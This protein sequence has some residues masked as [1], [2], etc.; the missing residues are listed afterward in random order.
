MRH[1]PSPQDFVTSPMAFSRNVLRFLFL[2]SLLLLI[3]CSQAQYD[4]ITPLPSGSGDLDAERKDGSYYTKLNASK[5]SHLPKGKPYKVF[6]ESYTPYTSAMGFEEIGVASWYGPGFHGKLTANGEKYNQNDITAAHKLLPFNTQIRVTNLENGRSIVVRINDRGPFSGERIIDLSKGAAAQIDMLHS[7]TAKVH[8]SVM[9]QPN[10]LDSMIAGGSQGIGFPTPSTPSQTTA[11]GSAYATGALS[12]A[13]LSGLVDNP[14][15]TGGLLNNPD[16]PGGLGLAPAK[17][18]RY[19]QPVNAVSSAYGGTTSSTSSTGS[20]ATIGAYKGGTVSAPNEGFYSSDPDEFGDDPSYYASSASS[21]NSIGASYPAITPTQS[22]AQPTQQAVSPSATSVIVPTQATAV[23]TPSPYPA[24]TYTPSNSHTNNLSSA[25]YPTAQRA[26]GTG[27]GINPYGG[28]SVQT[29]TPQRAYAPDAFQSAYGSGTT[30]Y[31]VSPSASV[32]APQAYI[33]AHNAPTKNQRSIQNIPQNLSIDGDYYLQVALFDSER[34]A[35][36]MQS[37][38]KSDGHKSEI[39]KENNF[40]LVQ[41]GPYKSD[42]SAIKAKDTLSIRFPTAF[43]V[44][45]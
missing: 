36:D 31:Q 18:N 14:F 1:C 17:H 26:I 34:L 4:T 20:S 9:G 16:N 45:R 32:P 38:L 10:S 8:L 42:D 30:V 40:Y 28:N 6:G 7:G 3:S 11:S 43:F 33:P 41:T 25:A 37:S 44:L 13:S 35:K 39:L 21:A 5:N 29:G 19:G 23:Y 2:S 27:G 12:S 15:A 24:Q 22:T